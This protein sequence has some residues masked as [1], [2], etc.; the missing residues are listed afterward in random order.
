MR[1]RRASEAFVD[2][3]SCGGCCRSWCRRCCT[4]LAIGWLGIYFASALFIAVFMRLG[5]IARLDRHR[6]GQ[7]RRD[8]GPLHPVRDLFLVPLPKGPLEALIGY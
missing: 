6:G 1:E 5:Q 3:A 7:P 8:R 2:G 4:S